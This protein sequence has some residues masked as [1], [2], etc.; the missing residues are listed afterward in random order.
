MPCSESNSRSIWLSYRRRP[1]DLRSSVSQM[2]TMRGSSETPGG[3]SSSGRSPTPREVVPPGVG[4][5]LVEADPTDE[6]GP[7][8]DPLAAFVEQ[9]DADLAAELV[10][11][12]VADGQREVDHLWL[13]PQDLAAQQVDRRQVVV[14]HGAEQLLV[15]LVAAEDGV[16]QVELDDRQ[17]P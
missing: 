3:R 9:G 10:V 16:G 2:S 6:V 7:R 5:V 13:E 11:D 15:A 4:E 14:A 1:A 12:V 17:P 8:H